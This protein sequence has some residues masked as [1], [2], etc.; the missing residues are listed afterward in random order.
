MLS[1]AQVRA[2]RAAATGR[3]EERLESQ[4][5]G[6][7]LQGRG[8]LLNLSICL[9]IYASVCLSI[10]LAVCVC[11]SILSAQRFGAV[12]QGRGMSLAI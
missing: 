9:S 6:T 7:V 1:H 2:H 12:L 3:F 11:I 8:T 10:Y 4:G 5:F